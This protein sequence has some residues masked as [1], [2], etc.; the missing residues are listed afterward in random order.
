M[1]LFPNKDG[2]IAWVLLLVAQK[3]VCCLKNS[4]V[5]CIH[6][7]K[8]CTSILSITNKPPAKRK[9]KHQQHTIYIH[10]RTIQT[11]QISFT[12]SRPS[13]RPKKECSCIIPLFLLLSIYFNINLIFYFLFWNEKE[14]KLIRR[15]FVSVLRYWIR[16]LCLL[17]I[18]VDRFFRVYAFSLAYRVKSYPMNSHISSIALATLRSV[19]TF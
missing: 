13:E 6:V 8:C 4:A 3:C 11:K 17:R 2:K 18:H 1:L 12:L 15:F 19:L 10:T 7:E 9:K 5:Y 14:K 16:S